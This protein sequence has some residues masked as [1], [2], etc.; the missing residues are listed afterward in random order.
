MSKEKM[1]ELNE[2]PQSSLP[3]TRKPYI[4][5]KLECFGDVRS[6]TLGGSPGMTDSGGESGSQ[7]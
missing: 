5:P 2:T 6:L 1:L 3:I 7:G 4:Q